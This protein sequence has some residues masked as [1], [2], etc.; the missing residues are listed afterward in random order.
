MIGTKVKAANPSTLSELIEESINPYTQIK[1]ESII[2][3]MLFIFHRNWKLINIR[4]G[5]TIKAASRKTFSVLLFRTCAVSPDAFNIF[6]ERSNLFINKMGFSWLNSKP[7]KYSHKKN[8][9]IQIL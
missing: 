5:K 6:K 9:A 7:L 8:K 1:M 4:K 2:G 3:I